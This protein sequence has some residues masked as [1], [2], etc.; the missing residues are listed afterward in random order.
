M[1]P[2][3]QIDLILHDNQMAEKDK[4]NTIE[5]VVAGESE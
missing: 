3:K 4:L 2:L 5:K 1:S